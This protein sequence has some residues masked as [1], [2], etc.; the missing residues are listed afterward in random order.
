M[1]IATSQ[2]YSNSLSTMENQQAQLLQVQ[3]QVSTGVS[4][5]SPADNPLGAAQAVQLSATSATLTQYASNQNTALSSLQ[6]EDST[7]SSVT[8]TLQSISQQIQSALNG[9]LNDSDRQ[10]LAKQLQGERSQLLTLANTTDGQGNYLFSGFKSTAQ[11]F[12]NLPGGGVQYNGDLGQR[13]VQVGGARQIAVS[14]TGAAVFQSVSAVGSQAVAAGSSAN[15]GTGTISGVTVT[16]PAQATN[17]DSY[18]ISFDQGSNPLTYTVTDSTTKQPVATSQPYTDGSAINLGNGMNVTISG[19]PAW[20]DTFSVT[21]ATTQQNSS[22]FSTIDSVIA[23]LQTPVN[24]SPSAGANLTNALQAGLT[25]IGNSISNVVT[26]QASVGGREQEV[27]ALQTV[28]STNSLQVTSNL[29]DLTTTDMTAA[30]TQYTQLS[31]ALTASQKSF[32]A[33]QN[34]SLFQYINP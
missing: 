1:R 5:S 18:S 30:I 33:T 24:G 28:T 19:T 7:L 22:V 20:N 31:N 12:T 9:S 16:D 10:A 8:S 17:G 14:D 25:A 13:L 4:L 2:I 32:A 15:T 11:V 3:Q 27:K 29:S 34:L 6:L 21:P 26:I 23:A